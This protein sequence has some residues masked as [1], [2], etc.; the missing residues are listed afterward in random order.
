ML[1]PSF[2]FGGGLVGFHSSQK[3]QP[4]DF[5]NRLFGIPT[6]D[7]DSPWSHI[8]LGGKKWWPLFQKPVMKWRS[9]FRSPWCLTRLNKRTQYLYL[10][11]YRCFSF[12]KGCFWGE[13]AVIVFSGVKKDMEWVYRKSS[14]LGSKKKHPVYNSGL[15]EGFSWDLLLKMWCHP[16]GDW[17]PGWGG[18]PQI[19]NIQLN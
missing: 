2:F 1:A 11:V 5:P 15:N 16:G 17:H 4:P 9:P 18:E 8:V 7:V 14:W 10:V 13:P 3:S 12:S 19:L 6:M